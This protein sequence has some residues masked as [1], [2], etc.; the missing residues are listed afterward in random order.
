MDR[1]FLKRAVYTPLCLAL[2]LGI[3][4]FVYLKI[5]IADFI[6]LYNNTQYAYHDEIIKDAEAEKTADYEEDEN[7]CV[8]D[9][10]KN[11]CVGVVRAGDGY[12]IRYDMD[13]SRIQ[14]SVSLVKGSKAFGDTGFAYIYSSNGNAKKIAKDKSFTIG[15]VFGEKSYTFKEKKSF[16]SE[17]AVLNYAPDCESAVIIYYR[18]TKTAGFTSD[19][20]ALVYEEVK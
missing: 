6:P 4:L 13:Y 19:Y 12:P 2:V 9:F 7:A 17:Y 1:L 11:Q 14:A 8:D 16:G 20:I 5:N 3:A 10:E 18:N 15:S